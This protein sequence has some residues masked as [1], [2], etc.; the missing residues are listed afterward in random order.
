MCLEL[1]SLE[2]SLK[3]Q[4]IGDMEVLQKAVM[5]QIRDSNFQIN[6][7]AKW[8]ASVLKELGLK[9]SLE[10]INFGSLDNELLSYIGLVQRTFSRIKSTE[11]SFVRSSRK[12]HVI[13][14]LDVR[15]KR[16]IWQQRES[17]TKQD[18]MT[19]REKTVD[20]NEAIE[21]QAPFYP[22]LP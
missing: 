13:I 2:M 18:L 15:P 14:N 11:A 4:E 19:H 3:L 12:R 8:A 10:R 20:L 22:V 9:K 17:P 7:L 6:Q 21:T 1:A 5:E 16:I